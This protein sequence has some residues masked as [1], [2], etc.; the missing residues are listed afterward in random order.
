MKSLMARFH[1]DGCRPPAYIAR[2]TKLAGS[3]V[4]WLPAWLMLFALLGVGQVLPA[5][6]FVLV[7]HRVCAEH[8][9]TL[10]AEPAREVSGSPVARASKSAEIE[11]KS[12]PVLPEHEHEHCSVLG[13]AR[14]AAAALA[15]APPGAP[16]PA[17]WE[18]FVRETERAAHVDIALLLYAPKLAPP[19]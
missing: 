2:V 9:E 10:H 18:R 4:H 6:H 11:L 15:S 12:A 19:V 13:V 3:R 1:L 8:G 14:S 7:A 17:P 5:L 16:L